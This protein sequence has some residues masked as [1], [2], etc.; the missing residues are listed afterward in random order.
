MKRHTETKATVGI[1]ICAEIPL[2]KPAKPKDDKTK[3]ANHQFR[4][5][6]IQPELRYISTSN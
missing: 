4:Y 3:T 5:T 6:D 2:L 1:L